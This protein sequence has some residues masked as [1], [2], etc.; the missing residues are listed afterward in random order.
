MAQ[1]NDAH[2][3]RRQQLLAGVATR[4]RDVGVDATFEAVERYRDINGATPDGLTGLVVR[5]AAADARMQ[6]TVLRVRRVAPPASGTGTWVRGLDLSYDLDEDADEGGYGAVVFEVT[7]LEDP[8]DGLGHSRSTAARH[9]VDDEQAVVEAIQLWLGYRESWRCVPAAKANPRPPQPIPVDVQ[10]HADLSLVPLARRPELVTH[11]ADVAP[12]QL[13]LHFPRDRVGR[14]AKRVAVALA[15]YG[16][17]LSKRGPW[18]VARAEGD[19]VRLGVEELIGTNQDHRWDSSPWLWRTSHADA[20]P[21]QRWQASDAEL[22]RPLVELLRDNQAAEALTLAGVDVDRDIGTLLAGYPT[23]HLRVEYTATWVTRLHD[24]LRGAAPWRF[25][26]AYRVWQRERQQAKRPDT[27][28][29]ILFG[30]KG[31]SQ[32][33]KPVVALEIYDGVPRLVMAWSGSNFRVPRTLW[34]RPADLEA[35]L[36]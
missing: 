36:E 15:G 20:T 35:A 9:L 19:S 8:D 1:V 6:V 33:R 31:L 2:R 28:P 17:A 14:Y 3:L 26:T 18:L 25:A 11:L 4:L 22:V 21:E 29:V 27:D 30:L 12:A 5:Q 34:E 24:Q 16:P 13:C 23:R 32:T 7:Q 10:D